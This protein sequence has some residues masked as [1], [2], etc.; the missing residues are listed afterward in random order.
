MTSAPA[1]LAA[2]SSMLPLVQFGSFP[3]ELLAHLLDLR[4]PSDRLSIRPWLG[5][6]A[7]LDLHQRIALAARAAITD[8]LM[9]SPVECTPAFANALDTLR[10][11]GTAV[12]VTLWHNDGPRAQTTAFFPEGI[13]GGRGATASLGDDGGYAV[14]CPV[15]ATDLLDFVTPTLATIRPDLPAAIDV[16][17]DTATVRVLAALLDHHAEHTSVAAIHRAVNAVDHRPWRLHDLV[18][19][20]SWST[21]T[22]S[23]NRV[24]AAV[25]ELETM[26]MVEKTAAGVRVAGPAADV[27]ASV[28][29]SA[30]GLRWH[31]RSLS[32][33]G[34]TRLIVKSDRIFALGEDGSCLA[35]EATQVGSTHVVSLGRGDVAGMLATELSS[36][37]CPGRVAASLR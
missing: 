3:R 2:S 6:A 36:A 9:A 24:S 28:A 29:P 20:A 23:K 11:P 8:P 32:D 1:D 15:E 10:S 17:A 21:S 7:P 14:T 37:S 35:I 18:V 5:D 30:G 34:G 22:V 25:A 4:G 27:A 16:H 26:G 19:A 33:E 13:V 31:R 12:E